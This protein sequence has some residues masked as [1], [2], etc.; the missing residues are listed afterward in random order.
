MIVMKRDASMKT[1]NEILLTEEDVKKI[2]ST[3][4]LSRIADA[5]EH[6]AAVMEAAP[7][8]ELTEA[9]RDALN[10]PKTRKR[11][12]FQWEG[13]GMETNTGGIKKDALDAAFLVIRE[14]LRPLIG[15]DAY[16]VTIE[17][18]ASDSDVTITYTFPDSE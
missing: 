7:K 11:R 5:L 18:K 6:I 1:G 10:Y 12:V 16:K 8:R 3:V 14:T 17:R 13:I 15:K 9:V 2:E 4:S